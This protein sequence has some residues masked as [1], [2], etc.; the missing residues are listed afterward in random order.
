MKEKDGSTFYGSYL[1][2]VEGKDTG[3]GEYYT[4]PLR[5][6]ERQAKILWPNGDGPDKE[7]TDE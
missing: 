1:I 2:P 7:Q 6:R 3:E 4:I 5:V